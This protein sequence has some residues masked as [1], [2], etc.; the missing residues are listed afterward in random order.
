MDHT[1]E[2]KQLEMENE[3]PLEELLKGY[4][5]DENYFQTNYGRHHKECNKSL[6]QSRSSRLLKRQQNK[7][8]EQAPE[9]ELISES[10]NEEMTLSET[11]SDSTCSE[12]EDVMTEDEEED[13]EGEEEQQSNL[14]CILFL[15]NS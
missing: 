5:L 13:D 11:K 3:L 14:K 10:G 9:E 1:N 15:N 6:A 4:N 7:N 2:L 8:S 12:D